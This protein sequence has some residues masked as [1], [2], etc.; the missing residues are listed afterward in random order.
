[1]GNRA[2]RRN[3]KKGSKAGKSGARGFG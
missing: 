2:S 3:A 1:M